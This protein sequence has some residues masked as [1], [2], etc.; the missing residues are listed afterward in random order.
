MRQGE[1]AGLQWS[2]IDWQNRILTVRYSKCPRTGEL[3]SPKSNKER[4]IP[5][6]I[7]VYEILLRRKQS[8]GYVFLDKGEKPFATHNL[9]RKLRAVRYEAGLRPLG[10]HLLRHTFASHLAMRGVPLH[11]VQKL[12]GHS[13]IGMTMRYSHVAPSTLR[14]AI[15]IL[16][17]RTGVH[18]DFGQPVGNLWSDTIQRETKNA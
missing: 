5:I 1:L 4:H 17:P 8:T 16:N 2:C 10:W 13:T 6:D 9:I 11:V 15:D 3:R 14:A 18:A 7:D 12:L